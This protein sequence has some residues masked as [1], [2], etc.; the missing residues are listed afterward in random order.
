MRIDNILLNLCLNIG[1]SPPDISNTDKYPVLETW[2]NPHFIRNPNLIIGNRLKSQYSMWLNRKRKPYKFT[3]LYNP[4]P[5]LVRSECLKV[6]EIANNTRV[7]FHYNGHGVPEPTIHGELWFFNREMSEYLAISMF[8]LISW[9][10]TPTIIILDCNAAG[11]ITSMWKQI[12][13]FLNQKQAN[14]SDMEAKDTN[15]NIEN[16]YETI[17][18][19]ACDENETLLIDSYYPHD[20][21]T[22]CLTTPVKMSLQWFIKT[23]LNEIDDSKEA[24]CKDYQTLVDMICD[25]SIGGKQYD[26]KNIFGELHWILLT[27]TDTIAWNV[28]P[29]ELYQKLYRTEIHGLLRNFLLAKRIMKSL[30]KNPVSYPLL[31]ETSNH[32]LWDI[33]DYV[34]KQQFLRFKKIREEKSKGININDEWQ[35]CDF[36]RVNLREFEEW[37]KCNKCETKPYHLPIVLQSLLVQ[38]YRVDVLILIAK[39]M[40]LGRHAIYYTLSI[41]FYPYL[42]LLVKKART[43]RLN[44]ESKKK[45]KIR[46][47]LTFIWAKI[48]CHDNI[49]CQDLFNDKFHVFFY[50]EL[51]RKDNSEQQ[52]FL[53][54]IILAQLIHVC[55]K[56]FEIFE[57]SKDEVDSLWSILCKNILHENTEIK[58]WSILCIA[59]ILKHFDEEKTNLSI[60]GISTPKKDIIHMLMSQ[61]NSTCIEVRVAV[62]YAL[63]Q[64]NIDSLTENHFLFSWFTECITQ[65]LS[66]VSV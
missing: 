30:N 52:I 15:K 66:T 44:V 6:R 51:K 64:L 46:Y 19:A 43:G 40:N 17:V 53:A 4:N 27:V 10:Q 38:K 37:I 28:F 7:I 35:H 56:P 42:R 41:A 48:L 65:S 33:W 60:Y 31:A 29:L 62:I 63:D 21:F 32:P 25:E 20:I 12:K 54:T 50:H 59:T 13:P 57:Q 22:S 18:L 14:K 61:L 1:V 3:P 55:I 34:V 45:K 36:F 11:K 2:R 24:N 26:R 23:K 49:S 47:L 5:E 16:I 39:Y 8:D 58:L 9:L